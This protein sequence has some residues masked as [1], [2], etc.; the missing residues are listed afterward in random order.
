M[1]PQLAPK[2]SGGVAV[3]L[4]TRNKAGL[5]QLAPKGSGAAAVL[6]SEQGSAEVPAQAEQS[7]N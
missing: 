3:L 4:T 2:G 1:R 5:P 7:Y 6:L